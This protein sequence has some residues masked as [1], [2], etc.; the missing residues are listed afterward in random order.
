MTL[1]NKNNK[2]TVKLFYKSLNNIIN[3]IKY[4]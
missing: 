3:Y 1:T 2:D 4:L